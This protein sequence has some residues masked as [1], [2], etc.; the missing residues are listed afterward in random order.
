M[1]CLI[2]ELLGPISFRWHLGRQ[3]GRGQHRGCSSCHQSPS[4]AAP[5]ALLMIRHIQAVSQQRLP[6]RAADSMGDGN[7]RLDSVLI[8]LVSVRG[9]IVL[10]FG[11]LCK[12][13]FEDAV[14]CGAANNICVMWVYRQFFR[15]CQVNF[16][17]NDD[18]GGE[19]HFQMSNC[20][21][22]DARRWQNGFDFLYWHLF[23]GSIW[24]K[25]QSLNW[26]WWKGSIHFFSAA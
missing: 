13:F 9:W 17:C 4:T 20:I 8:M 2:P 12:G 3:D 26:G 7:V 25:F 10:C 6:V 21:L 24:F 1:Q 5:A 16:I 15:R 19:N 22:L 14:G 11:S 18:R 23:E